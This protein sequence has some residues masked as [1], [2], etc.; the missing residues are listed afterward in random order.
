MPILGNIMRTVFFW[1]DTA[2][3]SFIGSV[4]N[5]MTDIAE[6]TIVSV[7]LIDKFGSRIYT[8]LGIFMLF[9]VSFSI[10]NYIVNPDDF[11]DK[12][13][14]FQ[15]LVTSILLA[16]VLLVFTPWIFEKAYEVQSIILRDNIISKLIVG[17]SGTTSANISSTNHGR[18]MGYQTLR[19]FYFIDED[20]YPSCKGIYTTG[21]DESSVTNC[22]N[23]AFDSENANSFIETITASAQA[24][25]VSMY[26]NLDLVNAKDKAGN[27]TMTYTPLI[28]TVCGIVIVLLL[29]SFCFDIAIRSVQLG[30]LQLIAPIPIIS[31]VDPKS[32]KDGMFGKWVKTCTK[33]YMD[34][35]IR[36][37]AIYFA[38]FIIGNISLTTQYNSVTNE[39]AN[40]SPL[41]KVFIILG[42]LMF[43]KK[44]PQLISDITGVKMDGKFTLNPF[45]K[46][47]EVPLVGAGAA[48]AVGAAD[49][50]IHGNGLV[51]GVKRN[52]GKV[53]LT[54]GDG[55]AS[56]LDTADRKLR[57]DINQK[58]DL[59]RSR[60]EGLNRQKLLEDQIKQG[61]D[62]AAQ[63]P[64]KIYHAEFLASKNAVDEAKG[65]MYDWQNRATKAQSDYTAAV[66]RYGSGSAQAQAAYQMLED[67]NKKSGSAQGQYEYLKKLHEAKRQQ[68]QDDAKIEDAIEAYEKAGGGKPVQTVL[69]YEKG[70][71]E[72]ATTAVNRSVIDSELRNTTANSGDWDA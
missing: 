18:T 60:Y 4:Y 38:V 28:S 34:L 32:G 6:T 47:S 66:Q 14:G 27:F 40:V 45:K 51:A 23:E 57:K 46:I 55:K 69:D 53:P 63:D 7:D 68:Y 37:A 11:L 30:F 25:S 72:A 31:R 59:A 67:V 5:L 49:S 33:T 24:S 64:E 20:N 50:A 56:I 70:L 52:W 9:K 15:K 43:A 12:S 42:A 17:P 13:K 58:A 44:L 62:Y 10:I 65:K 19:A 2:I 21:F 16:L 39:V 48:L 26:M 1:L 8:L 3:Y 41:V 71:R 36:L 29:I 35:F 54:G 22:A 61:K